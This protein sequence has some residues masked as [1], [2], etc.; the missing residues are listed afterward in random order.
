MRSVSSPVA[1]KKAETGQ[2]PGQPRAVVGGATGFCRS[3]LLIAKTPC[4]PQLPGNARALCG[5]PRPG[6][7]KDGSMVVNARTRQATTIVAESHFWRLKKRQSLQV[8]RGTQTP[9]PVRAPI[10]SSRSFVHARMVRGN[11]REPIRRQ[12][13]SAPFARP[14]LLPRASADT[15]S[16]E[17]PSGINGL[18]WQAGTPGSPSPWSPRAPSCSSTW[19]L[20]GTWHD[21][22]GA[23]ETFGRWA[24]RAP[25]R[26]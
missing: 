14:P 20:R 6:L 21:V 5:G 24:P 7:S 25:Q 8:E 12:A 3:I 1:E 2:E 18:P 10:S 4:P 16:G 13:S 17:E 9:A 23:G 26:E 22:A 15:H 11:G 19:I